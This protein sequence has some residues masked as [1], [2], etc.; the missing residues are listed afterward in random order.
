MARSPRKPKAVTN[1]LLTAIQFVGSVL[2][3]EGSPSETHILLSNGWAVAFNGVV[4]A[5]A[6]IKSDI[7]A[8]PN[9]KLFQ[10]ALAKCG[11][12]YSIVQEGSNLK[13]TSGKFKAIVPCLDPILINTSNIDPNIAPINDEFKIALEATGALASETGQTIHSASILMKGQSLIS[14]ENGV[15]LL[16]FWHGNNLPTDIAIPKALVAPLTKTIKKLTGFGCSDTSVTFYFEDGNFIKSQLYSDKW[17]DVGRIL[18]NETN[19]FEVPKDLWEGIAAVEKHSV[20]GLVYFDSDV[21]RSHPNNTVGASYE[22]KGLPRGPIF[23]IKQLLSIKNYVKKIDFFVQGGK[24]TI[25]YGDKCR[26]A[27]AGRTQ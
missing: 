2:K 12:E 26:G 3:D 18:N 20:D 10:A 25:W 7:Y 9:Y 16:E 17:P 23:N 6:S 27:I 11:D 19:P 21:I 15:V 13:I 4:G 1:E 24:L 22:I 5:G 14:T 8:A